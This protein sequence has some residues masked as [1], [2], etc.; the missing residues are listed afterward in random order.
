VKIDN[1]ADLVAETL[2]QAGVKR[3]FGVVGD[4]PTM[5]ALGGKEHVEY[6]NPYDVGFSLWVLRAVM[7]GRGDEVI[8]AARTNLLPR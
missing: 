1:V 5:H 8:D 2:A 4:S 7:S 6:D 3:I